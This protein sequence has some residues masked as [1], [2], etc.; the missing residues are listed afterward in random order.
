MMTVVVVMM[1]VTMLVVVIDLA[2]NVD[3][4]KVIPLVSK[5]QG[6]WGWK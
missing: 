2:N 1:V 5:K 3:Y 6:F 4:F